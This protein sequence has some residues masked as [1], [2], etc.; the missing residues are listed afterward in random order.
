MESKKKISFQE[1]W[2]NVDF[3]KPSSW[4]I[5]GSNLAVITFAVIDNLSAAEVM[6]IYWIQS[7]IIGLFN[8][9]RIL[10]LKNFTT[11]AMKI[12]GKEV[13]PTKAVKISTAF[14]FLFHYG[15]FHLVYATFLGALPIILREEKIFS[16]GFYLLFTAIV[17][18]INYGIEFYKEQATI[19]DEIPNLGV[20]MF[21]PYFRIIPM[22]LTIIIGGFIS[23]SG[24]FFNT[25]TSFLVIVLLMGI[26]TVV[27]LIT[28]SVNVF[29]GLPTTQKA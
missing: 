5:I 9:L 29:T 1:L 12:N 6:W 17:F 22:H 23:A 24:S 16:G 10:M 19:T 7:V 13:L 21:M 14:F 26:K 4:G 2:K 3:S 25:D 15:F 8:F 20:V 28:H 18:M 11:Q 27:D